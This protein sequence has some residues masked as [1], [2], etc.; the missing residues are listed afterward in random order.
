MWKKKLIG[1]L[2]GWRSDTAPIESDDSLL[3]TR[4]TKITS[5]AFSDK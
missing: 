2:I 5:L 1:A 3:L 4:L